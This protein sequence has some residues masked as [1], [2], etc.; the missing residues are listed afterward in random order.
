MSEESRNVVEEE[1]KNSDHY[2]EGENQVDIEAHGVDQ[3]DAWRNRDDRPHHEGRGDENLLC[4]IV[5]VLQRVTRATPQVVLVA[6]A[7]WAPIKELWKYR[8]TE[9]KGLKGVDPS[10]IE[11]WLESNG[12]VLQ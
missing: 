8:A 4:T 2:V 12:R 5:E 7:Q 1:I 11:I 9:F 3:A 10:S 6:G